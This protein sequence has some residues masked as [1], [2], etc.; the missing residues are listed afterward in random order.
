MATALRNLK[1]FYMHASPG[2]VPSDLT[3]DEPSLF[4]HCAVHRS[5]GDRITWCI[6]Y[7]PNLQQINQT[8][9]VWRQSYQPLYGTSRSL[10]WSPVTEL[11]YVLLCGQRNGNKR[12]P[13]TCNSH[14]ESAEFSVITR[15]CRTRRLQSMRWIALAVP[16]PGAAIL[17]NLRVLFHVLLCEICSEQYLMLNLMY[18]LICNLMF[19]CCY[20]YFAN[21]TLWGEREQTALNH[22]IATDI[23]RVTIYDIIGKALPVKYQI[24]ARFAQ[25]FFSASR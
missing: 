11:N 6:E 16:R 23:S 21:C 8:A 18:V 14:A 17:H 22:C 4:Y 20:Y 13:S 25:E 24:T 1:L 19:Y 5:R 9:S 7:F 2:H 12:R 15:S 3:G 10:L